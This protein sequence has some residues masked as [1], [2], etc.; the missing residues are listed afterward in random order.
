MTSKLRAVPDLMETWS[1]KSASGRTRIS[2]SI[3][4]R[5]HV[6]ITVT[7]DGHSLERFDLGY[8]PNMGPHAT[9]ETDGTN[10]YISQSESFAEPEVIE[11]I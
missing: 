7:R 4:P 10:L 8:E 2:A 6:L 1:A 3:G 9:L 11:I 5:G